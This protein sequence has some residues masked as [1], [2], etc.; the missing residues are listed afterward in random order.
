MFPE[1]PITRRAVVAAGL[2]MALPA[3][4]AARI[5]RDVAALPGFQAL[6]L[7]G[8]NHAVPASGKPTVVNFWA[9]WC[10]PCR[11]EM[12]LL[13]QMAE[14][15]NDRLVLQA[16]NYKERAVAV[17][18]HVGQAGWTVPVL[19]DPLGSGAEAWA[20]KVFPTTVGF[21]AQGQ[22]RWRVVGEYDWSSPE[23]G[24]LVE[25]LWR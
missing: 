23:A 14:F 1:G 12:P 20:V 22:P 15:Y 4:R 18:R 2:A 5:Q 8:R 13:Q 19:L 7:Q 16:V 21:D 17:Q 3:A 11:K 24:K 10:E 6:D 9:S 25:G